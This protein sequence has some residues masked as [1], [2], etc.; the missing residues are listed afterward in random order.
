[1]HETIFTEIMSRLNGGTLKM[2]AVVLVILIII[3]RII[4]KRNLF[5]QLKTDVE[6][7][8]SNISNY[9]ELRHNA[10][11][12]CMDILGVAHQND[13][14]AIASLGIE[15]A[16]QRL[17]VLGNKYPDLKDTPA[18]SAALVKIHRHGE[19]IAASKN[20]L[21]K[22]IQKYNKSIAMFPALIVAK[23]FGFERETFIDE[24]KMQ[25]NKIANTDEIDF[26][27]YLTLKRD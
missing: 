26:S 12:D 7:Q 25:S 23:I 22:A 1:M 20:I 24:E 6:T 17:R 5:V 21:N 27:Q 9:R 15:A 10:I 19:E 18:Y 8:M 2:I 3:A 13:V 4:K 14:D 11:K 16:S